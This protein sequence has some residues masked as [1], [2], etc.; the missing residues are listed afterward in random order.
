[1]MVFGGN[2]EITDSDLR[3]LYLEAKLSIIPLKESFQ[4]SGQSVALQSMS[5]GVPVMI[6]QTSGFWEKEIFINNENI[7]FID[8]FE[9]KSW[10]NKINTIFND[11]STIRKISDNAKKTVLEN[12]KLKKLYDFLNQIAI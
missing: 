1:M 5:L 7:F 3:N 2:K 9:Y 8:G 11:D 12:Y 6:T 4:P 10:V